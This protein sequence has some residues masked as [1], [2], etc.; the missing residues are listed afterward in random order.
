MFNN[1]QK[2]Y[3]QILFHKSEKNKKIITKK[4]FVYGIKSEEV[5][6]KLKNL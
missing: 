1:H 4:K 3:S 6:E 2:N 5:K